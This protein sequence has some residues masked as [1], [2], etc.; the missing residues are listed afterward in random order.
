MPAPSANTQAVLLLTSPLLQEGGKGSSKDPVLSAAEYAQLAAALLQE[1]HQ[2][3]DLINGSRDA[4]LSTLSASFTAERLNRLLARGFQLSQ[5]VE[6]WASRSISVIGRAD[7][8]YP[9]RFK[10]RL[11]RAAPPLLYACGNLELLNGPALAVVGSRST[12]ESLL[13]Q[14]E[15]VGALAAAAGVV[16]ASGAAK[17]VDEAAMAGSLAAGGFAIG[18]VADSLEK[19]SARPIWRQALLDGRLL[20]LSSEAPSARFQVWRAMGRNKLI[21]ALADAA[22]VVSSA[23]GE[24]GTWAGATE[25]LQSLRY[26]PVH[27]LSDPRGGPGLAALA[28]IGAQPWP[29]PASAEALQALLRDA[30]HLPPAPAIAPEQVQQGSLLETVP[31]ETP[32]PSRQPSNEPVLASHPKP[33]EEQQ[34]QAPAAALAAFVDEL[35]LGCLHQ[36][37]SIDQL[38]DL[39]DVSK[40]EVRRWCQRL[41]EQ[42]LARKLPKPV[43]YVRQPP[44]G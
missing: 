18:V 37:R 25:Q 38:A 3:A 5:A 32:Q 33:A 15:A 9:R 22:L 16:I 21:Y 39:L 34:A 10:Q 27:V 29:E 35:L 4:L 8:T 1:R 36:P 40:T 44:S 6:H 31:S 30:Q 43:R 7:A 26:C 41:V 11:K 20:L 14:A 2:P 19:L 24:G 13:R 28:E 12:P 17:G 23:K 42:G